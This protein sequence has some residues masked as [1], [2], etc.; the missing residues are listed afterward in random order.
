MWWEYAVVGFCRAFLVQLG[1]TSHSNSRVILE[2][3]YAKSNESFLS[4]YPS[5]TIASAGWKSVVRP[6][7]SPEKRSCSK[8]QSKSS[9]MLTERRAF[10]YWTSTIANGITRER[11]LPAPI[12]LRFWSCLRVGGTPDTEGL[13]G[14]IREQIKKQIVVQRIASA[15]DLV[16]S[17]A[18]PSIGR[19]CRYI[20]ATLQQTPLFG[21]ETAF[22]GTS[23]DTLCLLNAF[24]YVK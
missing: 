23:Q 4:G 15:G 1:Y 9:T 7:L 21:N 8:E 13:F 6:R 17:D 14:S 19:I 3:V 24:K 16:E 20:T 11:V 10:C 5:S 22:F 12:R 18:A 2:Y